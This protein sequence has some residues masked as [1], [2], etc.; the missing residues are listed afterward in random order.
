MIAALKRLAFGMSV[1]QSAHMRTRR[2]PVSAKNR[3]FPA[4]R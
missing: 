4:W 3:R 1:G 2:V